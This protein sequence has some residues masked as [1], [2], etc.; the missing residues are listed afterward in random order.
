MGKEV[1]TLNVTWYHFILWSIFNT[2]R[3][4]KIDFL[5]DFLMIDYDHCNWL[6]N[7][8]NN[9]SFK[10]AALR[11]QKLVLKK[12]GKMLKNRSEFQLICWLPISGNQNS[13]IS[14]SKKIIY[15]YIDQNC[16][17][18]LKRLVSLY[19]RYEKSHQPF[20]N[21]KLHSEQLLWAILFYE[22]NYFSRIQPSIGEI[23]C[24]LPQ[25]CTQKLKNYDI[26]HT[27]YY[28]NQ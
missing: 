8:G 22:I 14:I 3:T 2:N 10:D 9:G 18:S 23:C 28:G 15:T 25:K 17:S 7:R 26:F 21:R 5:T 27:F 11:I 16:I 4:Q 1:N 24:F 12:V 20:F 13:I 19:E 6:L